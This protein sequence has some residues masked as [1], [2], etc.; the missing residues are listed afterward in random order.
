VRDRAITARKQQDGKSF[1]FFNSLARS[2]QRN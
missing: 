2:R 1:R